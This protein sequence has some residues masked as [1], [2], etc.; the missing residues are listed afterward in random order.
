MVALTACSEG[1]LTPTRDVP[2]GRESFDSARQPDADVA[3]L[4]ALSEKAA[5]RAEEEAPDAVLRQL[6]LGR[7]RVRWWIRFTDAA[8]T[9]EITV[10]V[11]VEDVPSGEWEVRTGI[12]PLIGH[13]SLGLSLE[14]L[15]IGPAA[16]V[17]AATQHW[18]DCPVRGLTLVGE[19]HQLV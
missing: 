19:E 2:G 15:R 11:P 8:A 4:V 12:S 16:V 10:L 7:D 9:W 17:K 6:D 3:A 13:Q 18:N 14:G 1:G 5:R